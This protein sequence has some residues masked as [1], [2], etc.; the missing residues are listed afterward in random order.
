M[1]LEDLPALTDFMLRSSFFQ[2]G[3]LTFSRLREPAWAQLWH[4][5]CALLLLPPPSSCGCTIFVMC[6]STSVYTLLYGCT[7]CGQSCLSFSYRHSR[8]LLHLEFYGAPILLEDV[9]EEKF[10]G[11]I[12]S[13]TQGTIT[14]LQPVDATL[15]HTLKSV[16]NR[17]HVLSAL[18]AR[19]RTIIRLTRPMRLIRPQV[20]DLIEIYQGRGFSRRCLVQIA[21]RLLKSVGVQLLE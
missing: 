17:E 18:S 2:C 1:H 9:P 4:Q 10:L 16:G 3:T 13:V 11:T 5:C 14:T 8:L 7:V 15:L 19:T 21:H 12:C 6:C 20:E